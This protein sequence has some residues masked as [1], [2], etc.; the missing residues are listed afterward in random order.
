MES[1]QRR[2]FAQ[3]D[4]AQVQEEVIRAVE[5][6]PEPFIER[7]KA[8]PDNF[9]GRYVCADNFKDTFD[10]FRASPDARNRYNT[11]VHNAAA[12][13]S[14]ELYRR[15]LRD[16]SDP[17]RNEVIFLT[18]VPGA[19]KTS[20]VLSAGVPPRTRVVFEGQLNRPEPSME[21][22]QAAI[23]AGLRPTI[24]AVQVTPEV[25]LGRTFKRFEEYGR[26]AS[27]AV[28]ADI[29]G[30]LP[31]GLRKIHDRFG[32]SVGLIIHDGRIDGQHK[33]FHGWEHVKQL[34]QEGNHERIAQRLRTELDRY[35]AEGR[36]SEACYRQANGDAPLPRFAG[37]EQESSSRVKQ[38]VDRRELPQ[39][40][41]EAHPVAGERPPRALAFERLTEAEGLAQHPE[42][43]GAY[44]ELAAKRAEAAQ[45]F[46]RNDQAQAAHL[47]AAR[48]DI[49]RR[50]D[51][52]RIPPLPPPPPGK[53]AQ[54]RDR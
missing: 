21:K 33:E 39:G 49:Q 38:D 35:K 11:P 5:A 36:I 46:P 24:V 31:E 19:G 13:L 25:A 10:Q 53:S 2:E 20:K 3:L 26:G 18:G 29:Q 14:S 45:Q 22:M 43:T 28:M 44:R 8:H 6:N 9:G 51:D 37:L 7:Y 15:M 47:G 34:S 23:D 52:G 40:N 16:D 42:L 30:G 41:R 4:R 27:I 54:E 50:L 12:V 32:D 48:A 17:G 1:I